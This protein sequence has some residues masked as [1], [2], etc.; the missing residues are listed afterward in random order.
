MMRAGRLAADGHTFFE[1]HERRQELPD[2][3]GQ[4]RVLSGILLDAGQFAAS[5]P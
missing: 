4:L 5:E 3:V 2:L 1:L